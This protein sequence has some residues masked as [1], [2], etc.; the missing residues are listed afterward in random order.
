MVTT[1]LIATA[2][3]FAQ[4]GYTVNYLQSLIPPLSPCPSFLSSDNIR[5]R[6]V[7]PE[8]DGDGVGVWGV[9]MDWAWSRHGVGMTHLWLLLQLVQAALGT[10]PLFET[11]SLCYAALR[12]QGAP[13]S[14][15][16]S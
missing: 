9:G 7:R 16:T 10:F 15:P 4:A 6:K 12:Q 2:A 8:Q 14:E 11:I 3:T 13:V 5:I 1:C